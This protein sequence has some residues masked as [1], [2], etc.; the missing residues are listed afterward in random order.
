MQPEMCWNCDFCGKSGIVVSSAGI[1]YC[2]WCR[3][4]YG[5][6]MF[7]DKGIQQYLKKK[8]S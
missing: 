4:S 5:E 2:K 6:Q 7:K 1:L 3:K 8:K